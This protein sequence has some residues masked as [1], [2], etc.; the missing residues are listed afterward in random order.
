MENKAGLLPLKFLARQVC[1]RARWLRP[2]ARSG[3]ILYL[4][5]N[6]HQLFDPIAVEAV[7]VT[8]ATAE[9]TSEMKV[10]DAR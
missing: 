9:R 10:P 2:E 1:V 7:L 3:R 5:A 6:G 4:N 8:R